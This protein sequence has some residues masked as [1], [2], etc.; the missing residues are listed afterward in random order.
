MRAQ[1]NVQWWNCMFFQLYQVRNFKTFK[2]FEIYLYLFNSEINL[3]SFSV[4]LSSLRISTSVNYCK[5][6]NWR[7]MTKMYK[8]HQTFWLS[9]NY[10]K[11]T[12]AQVEVQTQI[13]FWSDPVERT[14]MCSQTEIAGSFRKFE[15]TTVWSWSGDGLIRGHFGLKSLIIGGFERTWVWSEAISNAIGSDHRRIRAHFCLIRGDF[16]SNW[17]WS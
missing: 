16:E 4:E 2:F 5:T 6:I 9:W 11:E 1:P 8:Q 15:R 7:K 12:I 3:I 17:I 13:D 14:P 10:E